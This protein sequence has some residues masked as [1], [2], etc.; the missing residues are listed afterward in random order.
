[1]DIIVNIGYL[2]EFHRGVF[3]DIIVN[4]DYLKEFQVP[5][6]NKVDVL[7]HIS[8]YLPCNY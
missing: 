8:Y 1:M 6:P 7:S 5:V 4:I 3:F 2:K